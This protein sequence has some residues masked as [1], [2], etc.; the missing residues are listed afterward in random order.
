[1][2][3]ETLLK[4][5]IGFYEQLEKLA[6]TENDILVFRGS[7]VMAYKETGLPN[8]YYSQI[9][10]LL[11]DQGCLEIVLAGNRTHESVVALHK[12]PNEIPEDFTLGPLTRAA[13]VDKLR[14]EVETLKAWREGFHGL[15]VVKAL[16]NIEIRLL[17][18][19]KQSR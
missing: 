9:R 7:L 6:N 8:A 12:A 19:E 16:S 10:R 18:L 14:A 1:M 4:S 2:K 15:D 13:D 5:S 11:L 17:N 3:T